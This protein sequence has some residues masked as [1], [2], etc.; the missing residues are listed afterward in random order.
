MVDWKLEN[1]GDTDGEKL[2]DTND[3]I[4]VAIL[5]LQNSIKNI[6][7]NHSLNDRIMNI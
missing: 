1:T 6:F 7:V 2:A 3:G 4:D 5:Y